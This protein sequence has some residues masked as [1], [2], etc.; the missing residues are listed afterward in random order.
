MKERN[1]SLL[2]DLLETSDLVELRERSLER[3]LSESR[4]RIRRRRLAQVCVGVALPVLLIAG[5]LLSRAPQP[6][7]ISIASSAPALPVVPAEE[8]P[9]PK[10]EFITTE[11]LLALFPDRP[12][13]LIGPPGDKQKLVFFDEPLPV[14]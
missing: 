6:P 13:A 10:V 9:R 7:P 5:F 8:P 2:R 3:M 4:S 12:L 14:Q 1:D 11:E